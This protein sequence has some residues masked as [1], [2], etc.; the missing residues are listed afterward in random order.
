MNVWQGILL[1]F[2]SFGS[3]F[4]QRV[5]GFGLGI[6]AMIFLPHFLLTH[7]A[8]AAISSLLSSVASSYNTLRYRKNVQYKTALP[9]IG[10]ALV[11][12]PIAVHFSANVP[13]EL[14]QMLLGAV[15]I[16][17]SIYFMFFNK[18]LKIRPTMVNGIITPEILL[19]AGIGII[20]CMAGDAVGKAVFDKLDGD[21]LK[22]VIYVGMIISGVILIL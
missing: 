10:A 7:T 19:Y 9:M 3:G 13:K 8:A 5:S 17:L 14:F 21:K 11:S 15:L 20:G 4:V 22:S 6:F 16:I 12:I 2:I 1:I 18:H